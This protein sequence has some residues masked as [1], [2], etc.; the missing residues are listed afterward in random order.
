MLH[1][2]IDQLIKLFV[3]DAFKKAED[4]A[5]A[6]IDWRRVALLEVQFETDAKFRIAVTAHFFAKPQHGG[7]GHAGGLRQLADGHV[8]H[9]IFVFADVVINHQLQGVELGDCF[10][11]EHESV[12][13]LKTGSLSA[14]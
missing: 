5:D 14:G 12:R 4:F 2:L 6:G 9:L 3:A 10:M 7:G 13:R 8:H 1:R 11:G